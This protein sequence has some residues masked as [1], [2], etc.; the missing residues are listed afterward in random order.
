[1]LNILILTCTQSGQRINY[2]N[3][4]GKLCKLTVIS[5]KRTPDS[6]LRQF[7]VY[8]QYYQTKYLHG[9]PM[10]KYMAFCPGIINVLR[11]EIYD[12]IIVEQ[13]ASPTSIMA[14][15]Y[16]FKHKIPFVI[17]ADSG[18]PNE[19]ESI[20]LKRFKSGLIS[21]ASLWI[22]GGVGGA[23]YIEYYGGKKDQIKKFKFSPYSSEDQPDHLI[24]D[25]EKKKAREELGISEEKVIVTAGQQIHRK[26]F[27]TL[28]RAVIDEPEYVGTYIIGGSPNKECQE[29]LRM[30]PM[31]NVHFPGF[32]SK[33]LLKKY[34]CAA[35]IFV[36]P[37]RYDIWGYPIN[38]ALSFGLPIITTKQCNAGVE[39]IVNGVNGFLLECEDIAGLTEKI[40][41]LLYD[42]EMRTNMG[43][44]NYLKSKEYNSEKMAESV[45][46]I[47]YEYVRNKKNENTTS[48]ANVQ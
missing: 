5:E 15:N 25:I 42:N 7:N 30:Y 24:T 18:F 19:S 32:M 37:T 11:Q 29:V 26:G 20:M 4:L 45:F 12:V 6:V 16:L 41:V 39:L 17:N 27:D 21:K 14:I 9:I 36:F 40:N 31:S 46:Q 35:D 43:Y 34:Y 33:D 10:F 1:M 8:P 38:E 2:Y 23:K 3:S 13:Y 44:T 48:Y 47:L 22:T 28:L